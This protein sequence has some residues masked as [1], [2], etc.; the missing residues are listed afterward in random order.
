MGVGDRPVEDLAVTVPTRPAAVRRVLIWGA[1]GHGLAL[2]ELCRARGDE[3]AVLVDRDP[4]LTSP[5]DDVELVV[6]LEGVDRW[7]AS[8]PKP[9][10]GFAI[11]IG[12]AAGADRLALDQA[13][14]HRGLAPITLVHPHAY[15]ADDAHLDAGAQVLVGGVVG[16][17]CRVGRQT[18]VNTRA[19][20]DHE[21]RIGDGVHIGPGA[22]LAGC[23][24]VDD[25]AFIG[26]GATVLPRCR[27]AADA[28]VG[29]GATVVDD[30]PPGA[31]VAGVP[32][33]PLSDESEKP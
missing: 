28:V 19:G 32:A 29:A 7:L 33:R 2:A 21:C 9:P 17:R 5:L 11:A 16:T 25:R 26:A 3:V 10:D 24:V 4:A 1:R 27:I 22:T 23:V 15:V 13:L 31:V 6:G 12:G 18:I 30:V 14:G 8:T 20:I